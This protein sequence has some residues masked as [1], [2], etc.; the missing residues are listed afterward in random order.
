MLTVH[1]SVELQ[2]VK[3][4]VFWPEGR[5]TIQMLIKDFLRL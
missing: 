4:P 1:G 2:M 3:D 5:K